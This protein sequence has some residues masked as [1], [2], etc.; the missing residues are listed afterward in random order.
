MMKLINLKLATRLI[1]SFALLS[2][3]SAL[4]AIIGLSSLA[5]QSQRFEDVV[6]DNSRKIAL[7]QDLST[8]IHA[9]AQS[10]SA[11][12][13][14][15]DDTAIVNQELTQL[16]LERAE[17]DQNWARLERLP[18]SD[19]GLALRKKIDAGKVVARAANDAVIALVLDKKLSEAR[20]ALTASATP[21]NAIWLAALV[22]NQ[23]FQTAQSEEQI[24]TSN[25][26]MARAKTLLLA[27]TGIVIVGGI[28]L[29]L[30]VTGSIQQP[31]NGLLKA[32]ADVVRTG[33]LNQNVQYAGRD[34][35]ATLVSEF[36][37]MLEK[38]RLTT[39]AIESQNWVNTGMTSVAEQLRSDL[40][41]GEL[42]RLTVSCLARYTEAQAAALFVFDEEHQYLS[43]MASFAYELR[44]GISNR[45]ALGEGLV[46]QAALEKQ[47]ISVTNLPADYSRIASATGDTLPRNVLVMP[48]VHEN[49]I[50]GVL[51]LSR[52]TEFDPVALDLLR[53]AGDAIAVGLHVAQSAE[54][55][56]VL[57]AQTLQQAQALKENE[58]E[59]KTQ[60]EEL[61]QTNE[62]L[63]E[64]TQALR[65][66]ETNLKTQQEELQQT[67]EVLEEQAQALKMSETNLKAQQ[68]ELRQTN[69]V[70]ETQK[71]EVNEKNIALKQA[72]TELQQESEDLA[73]ASKY[74]S[75]FLSNM[76]H[77]LRTP[78]NSMLILSRTLADNRDGNL[79]AKQVESARIMHQ[80]GDDLLAIIN[81][82]LDL[83]KIEAGYETAVLGELE[84]SELAEQLSS[85][86]SIV[87][88]DKGVNFSLHHDP[89]LP[90]YLISDRQRVGQILRNLLSNAFKFTNQGG[91]TLTLAPA[92]GLIIHPH[93]RLANA[94]E[95]ISLSVSDTGIGIALEKQKQIW[96]A[97][98]QADGSTSREFGGTGLGLTISRELAKLLGGE[99]RV[100]SE[101][102]KGSTF[103]LYLP[104]DGPKEVAD[105]ADERRAAQKTPDPVPMAVAEVSRPIQRAPTAKPAA[106]VKEIPIVHIADD[107][108]GLTGEA[109]ILIVEDD[110]GFAKILG[111]ICHEKGFKYIAC[112][113]AEEA[114]EW[115]ALQTPQAVLL[116]MQL[117]KRDG[118]SVLSHIK[119]NPST[120]HI[121]VY[122]MSAGDHNSQV[123]QHGAL[124]FM[125]KPVSPQQLQAAFD[126]LNKVRDKHP[127]EILLIEDDQALRHSVHALLE[128]ADVTIHEANTG[129][130]ALA[131]MAKIA[132]DLIVLDLGLPD[133]S[134]FEVLEQ[135]QKLLG[136]QMPPVI[137]FTGR[138]LT[139]TEHAQLNQHSASV[140]LK[141]VRSDERLVEE[142][143]LFLHRRASNLPERAR[144]MMASIHDREA[145]FAGKKVL[146][147]DDDLRNI[148][149]LS[150]LL[151]ERGLTVFT[152]KNGEEALDFLAENT[153]IDILLTDVM[154][155][156][157]DGY[158]LI[159]R[160][161]AQEKYARLPILALT[162]K[163]MKADRE[164]CMEVGASDYLSKP[165]NVDRLLSTMR[166]WL[167]R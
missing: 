99:L 20:V 51:E 16:K 9:A 131:R 165:V 6:F 166:V 147:V 78:L 80:S 65:E 164:R 116:D 28:W 61:Q 167:Y 133:M 1:L 96:E 43:L 146:L 109:P 68:E 100:Q 98:Q 125:Q 94:G 124:G 79:S 31:V 138:D 30:L 112:P 42:S 8:S 55:T 25:Q 85:L 137:V 58:A 143:A 84:L 139:R 154:M 88:E 62:V 46:G 121:P 48:L 53:R 70:L 75:E 12:I 34:E 161:R 76:S 127:K 114:I 50:K 93:S 19:A 129:A 101:L 122:V 40:S 23:A 102:G 32:M 21:L 149:A 159:Q 126:A 5:E 52:V 64:Q 60:Q 144:K 86:Y 104:V 89:A 141:S 44:K 13:L 91:V 29:G 113:T 57:L 118:W 82:I 59:L 135:A 151:E 18:A 4:I 140:I 2:A 38:Q 160:V 157:M 106:R 148:F 134:G 92:R 74:K 11:I 27:I 67:N 73:A 63:E 132:I 17:Y 22:E 119:E 66:S 33:D 14:N 83:S 156:G 87:A 117:P 150:G 145:L 95:I 123:M 39:E 110:P 56:R 41:L 47:L 128:S 142:V 152:A 155:P 3:F 90:A 111:E 163:V 130:E 153:G 97:F 15:G 71:L 37:G 72:Q 35:F 69:E 77:E 54:N 136:A 120:L 49:Q 103:T 107:R 108:D 10:I 115:L 105:A 7:S 81:D 36:N 45:F 24:Q 162:A 26:E 158:E